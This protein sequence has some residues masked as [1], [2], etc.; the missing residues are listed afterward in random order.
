MGNVT[1][2]ESG[3]Y[4]HFIPQSA[5]STLWI[6]GQGEHFDSFVSL[7]KIWAVMQMIP[8]EDQG[9]HAGESATDG[10]N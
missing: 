9:N 4:L 7:W 2:P 5:E 1:S 10:C 8:V 6:I 3:S